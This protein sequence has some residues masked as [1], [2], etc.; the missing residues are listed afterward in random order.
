MDLSIPQLLYEE[1]S[2]GVFLLVTVALGG[3]AAWLMGRAVAGT[4]RPWWQIVVYSL[5]VAAAVR[6]IHFSLFEGTLLSPY[7]YTVDAAVCLIA[8]FVSFRATRASQ[9]VR[10]YGWINAR[11]GYFSWARR[12]EAAPVNQ[13]DSG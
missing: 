12:S 3:G 10:Q 4:W 8:G 1:D 13:P 7:Y 9:M 2:V 11:A 5:M 6:F